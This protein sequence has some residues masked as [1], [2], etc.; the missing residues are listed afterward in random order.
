ME[1]TAAPR[2]WPAGSAQQPSV[3]NP[4][5]R[6]VQLLVETSRLIPWT[7][8]LAVTWVGSV[9]LWIPPALCL[10]PCP[11]GAAESSHRE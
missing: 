6:W 1:S 7:E 10:A 8:A 4:P 5:E 11:S 3:S 2:C 9:G